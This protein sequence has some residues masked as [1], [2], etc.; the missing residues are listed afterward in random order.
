MR[1]DDSRFAY[2]DTCAVVDA[3]ILT[4]LCGRMDVNTRAAM[5]QFR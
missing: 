3:E 1:T 5:R 2:D 4:Y